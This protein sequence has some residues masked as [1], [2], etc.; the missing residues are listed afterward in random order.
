MTSGMSM[1][2]PPERDPEHARRGPERA[3]DDSRER[4]RMATRSPASR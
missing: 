2:G 4:L 1:D 3:P